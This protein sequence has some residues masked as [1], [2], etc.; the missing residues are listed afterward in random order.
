MF[1]HS[2]KRTLTIRALL[3][4][5]AMCAS[6]PMWAAD[7]PATPAAPA[8]TASQKS[9]LLEMQDAFTHIALTAE[10][11]VVNIKAAR[12][13]DTSRLPKEIPLGPQAPT[14]PN[15]PNAPGG[16]E[17]SPFPRRAESTGSGAI[18][19]PDGY[20]I[21][22]DH[23]VEGAKTVTVTLN[24][25]REFVGEVSADR[26]SDLAIVKINPGNVKLP[27]CLFADSDKVQAG[28]WAIAIGSPFDLQNTMTV[29]VVSATRRHQTIGDSPITA[30][31]YP[32]LIQTDAAINPGNSGGPLI[33]IDGR[34]IGINVAI[35]SPV[36][37]SA[38]VGFAIP[39][40]IATHI[41]N[42]L[43]K[44]GK[45]TRGFLGLAPADL[46]PRRIAETGVATGAWIIQVDRDSPAGRAGIHAADIIQSFDDKVVVDELSLRFAIAETQPG[47]TV[48]IKLIRDG[49]PVNV[50]VTI[51][52][53]P[54]P[55]SSGKVDT[56]A[57]VPPKKIGISVRTLT[58]SDR[59]HAGL[60]TT[61]TGAFVT[62]V[63]SNSPA[64]RAGLMTGDIIT[65]IGKT[66]V[67]SADDAAAGLATIAPGGQTT[68]IITRSSGANK[69][70]EI[71]LD[72]K[73]WR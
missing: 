45:V 69:I 12:T 34:V 10:P 47:K 6:M 44:N 53:P 41:M 32:D 27:Y 31:Y 49:N 3:S 63:L 16:G 28:Q 58:A 70:Q 66:L 59:E 39:A 57:V 13:M 24:D 68:V 48:P 26:A 67:A 7:A 4:L 25:G 46:G 54:A 33:D 51:G 19:S 18:V 71:A 37:G 17:P 5:G 61:A 2:S 29:G 65:R 11:F 15:S 42:E 73:F 38:G 60:D 30:R 23:V 52:T 9:L 64:E 50:S 8:T 62:A 22:N 1:D 35:E 36:E 72:L 55:P 21:T 14:T 40:R 20:I 56:P 43:I